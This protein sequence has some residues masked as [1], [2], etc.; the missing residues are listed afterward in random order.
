MYGHH[1]LNEFLDENL[2]NNQSIGYAFKVG[3]NNEV[4]YDW[5]VKVFR[6]DR[7]GVHDVLIGDPTFEGGFGL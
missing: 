3:K 1:F 6:E 7:M 2:I 4:R 5:L